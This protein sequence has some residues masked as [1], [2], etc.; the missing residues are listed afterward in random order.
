MCRGGGVNHGTPRE[1]VPPPPDD[2]D[3]DFVK[4]NVD[5]CPPIGYDDLRT[6]N[7]G[8]EDSDSDGDGDR[9]EVDDDNDGVFDW[10]DH[11]VDWESEQE[12]EDNCRMLPNPG[13]EDSNGNNVGDICETDFDEDGVFDAT[14]NCVRIV[15]LDQSDLDGDGIG[16]PCDSDED[17]D[18][19]RRSVDNC[20]RHANPDQVDADGD[21]IGAVCD[22]DEGPPAPPIVMPTPTPLPD[23]TVSVID[24]QAP[25][26]TLSVRATQ[27]VAEVSDGVIVRVRCSEACTVKA[28]LTVSRSVARRLKLRRTRVVGTGTAMLEGASTTYAFVRFTRRGRARLFRQPRTLLTLKISATD[29]AGNIRREREQLILKRR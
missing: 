11:R 15:N 27:R 29:P 14:D 23:A 24:R 16:D 4:D 2:L 17:G 1:Q 20:P 25:R 12:P 26:V 18:F 10:T 7:P 22:P 5:N 19:F 8:Q 3:C 28:E 9:C 13:Q 6:R 21:G